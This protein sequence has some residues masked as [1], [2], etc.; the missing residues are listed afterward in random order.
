MTAFGPAV[1]L[2]K[3]LAGIAGIERAY[4]FGSWAARHLGEPGPAPA[5]VDVLVVGTPDRNDVYRAAN[6]A[7]DVLHREVNPTIVSPERWNA[8]EE[9]FIREVRSAPLIALDFVEGT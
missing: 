8:A 5:D 2:G 4:L 3:A 6:A 1:V 9:G 7:S